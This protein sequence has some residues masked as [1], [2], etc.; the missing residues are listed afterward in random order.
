MRAQ[1]LSDE[2]FIRPIQL[3]APLDGEL[4]I[5]ATFGEPRFNHFHSG[6]DLKTHGQINKTVRSAE[7]GYV[8]RIKVSAT[9]YGHALYIN[10]PSGL[11]TVYAHLNHFVPAIDA[12][13]KAVQYQNKS[14]AL[15]TILPDKRFTFEK[16]QQIAY[17]GNTGG[18]SG[19]HLHF[20]VRETL[21][22]WALN[23]MNFGLPVKDHLPPRV[24]S[25]KV[26][27]IKKSFYDT[28]GEGWALRKVSDSLWVKNEPVHVPE[29][30]VT[31]SVEAFDQQDLTPHNRNGIPIVRMFVNDT[32]VFLRNKIKIDFSRT[33]YVHAEVDYRALKNSGL[34]Y[35][36]TCL[37]PN[38]IDT[39]AYQG[40]PTNGLLSLKQGEVKRIEIQLEDF[41]G[42]ISKVRFKVQGISTETNSDSINY[43]STTFTNGEKRLSG[44]TLSWTDRTFYDLIPSKV[45]ALQ[46][47]KSQYSQTYYIFK[48]EVFPIQQGLELTFNQ[49]NIPENL[50]SKTVLVAI[51]AKNKKSASPVTFIAHVIKAKVQEAAE[52]Y[53]D[54]DTTAPQIKI[55][56][57]HRTTETFTGKKIQVRISDELSGIKSYSGYIDGKW[58]LFEYDAKNKL[59]TYYFDQL[60][61]GNHELVLRVT[62]AVN[63][64]QE[65]KLSLKIK[66]YVRSR[67]KSTGYNFERPK[68]ARD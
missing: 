51:D 65:K 57:L 23:P 67:P 44:A 58:V 62:D 29:G 45:K 16:G 54:V 33:K 32:L 9:G 59:L 26:Y 4:Y 52:V 60:P 25:L 53:L 20:E 22:E 36:L 56:N 64:I 63:N 41:Q 12:W 35:Y 11:T 31:F 14:F 42:N 61:S 49:W 1:K 27:P 18:S 19:P 8:S 34:D 40:S 7:K 55:I 39:E 47:S 10:H 66:K 2:L 15:D 24:Q 37:L 50:I 17:S 48:N 5:N 46:H 30:K 68:W 38:N 28:P 13:V 43:L 21:S 6:L 3:G